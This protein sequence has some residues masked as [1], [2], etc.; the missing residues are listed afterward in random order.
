LIFSFLKNAIA[1]LFFI[2]WIK[3]NFNGF[4]NLTIAIVIVSLGDIIWVFIIGIAFKSYSNY[5][6]FL[7]IFVLVI[8]V[9]YIYSLIKLYKFFVEND[10]TLV[11]ESEEKE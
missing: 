2:F 3:E 6:Y 4:K 7:I 5:N 1:S 11:F 10:K 9:K 8:L